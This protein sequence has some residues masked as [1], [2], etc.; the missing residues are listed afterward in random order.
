MSFS[1]THVSLG[2]GICRDNVLGG[3]GLGV[4]VSARVEYQFPR[5]T[6]LEERELC[7]AYEAITGRRV[8]PKMLPLLRVSH[9]RHGPDTI[10]LLRELFEEA[11]VEDL[12]LRLRDRPPRIG[13]PSDSSA[14]TLRLVHDAPPQPAS[15][16]AEPRAGPEEPDPSR[17]GS[18][19][20][21][22]TP[23][24]RPP[25]ARTFEHQADAELE[26]IPAETP[27]PRR[28]RPPDCSSPSHEKSWVQ[29][30][31][32]TWTCRTCHP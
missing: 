17:F 8:W 28:I 24:S 4:E 13:Q 6:A 19:T 15:P 16:S 27:A 31:D 3:K 23:R 2:I 7:D 29:R 9:R 11:G 22:N 30:P 10:P 1:R 26:A 18:Q 21:Q 25:I 20:K 14:P 12:L 5:I 32:G